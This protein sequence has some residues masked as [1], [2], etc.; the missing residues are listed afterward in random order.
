[1]ATSFDA[2]AG[3]TAA[4][5]TCRP[6]ANC[7]QAI[8]RHTLRQRPLCRPSVHHHPL[9][10]G[11]VLDLENVCPLRQGQRLA[12]VDQRDCIGSVSLLNDPGCPSTVARFVVPVVVHP[13]DRE[14]LA[15]RGAH[16]G[17]EGIQRGPSLADRDAASAVMWVSRIFWI[18]RSTMHGVPDVVQRMSMQA[19][20][21]LFRSR[22]FAL[23]ASTRF[24][25]PQ[26][27]MRG[28]HLAHLSTVTSTEPERGPVLI[29]SSFTDHGPSVVLVPGEVQFP[30]HGSIVSSVREVVASKEL[31]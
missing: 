2:T 11:V 5:A 29:L 21:C 7:F 20:R 4:S 26:A 19:V 1:M 14:S 27:K 16:V 17:H 25:H 8:R 28:T 9:M 30:S 10:Q 22:N 31:M 12:Q 3:R 6:S 24:A 15:V 18:R 13:V 23:K